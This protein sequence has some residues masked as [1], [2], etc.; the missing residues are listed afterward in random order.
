MA[1]F[2]EGFFLFLFLRMDIYLFIGSIAACGIL[3]PQTGTE[4]MPPV[5]EV[6]SPTTGLP[7]QSH[8]GRFS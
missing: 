1:G 2:H 8:L 5:V 4:P 7:E 3:V 6:Q